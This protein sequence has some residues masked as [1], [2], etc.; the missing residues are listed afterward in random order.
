MGAVLYRLM[1]LLE[2]IKRAICL[3]C[4]GQGIL[5]GVVVSTWGRL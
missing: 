1:A 3:M 5:Y 4:H 2:S